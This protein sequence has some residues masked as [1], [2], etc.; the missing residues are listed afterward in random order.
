MS[1][2]VE[3]GIATVVLDRPEKLNACTLEEHDQIARIVADVDGRE[4]VAAVVITGAGRAFSVGGDLGLL[5]LINKHPEG[6]LEHLSQGARAVVYS[7]LETQ[8]PWVAAVNGPAMGVGTII[9]LLCDF[10]VMERSARIA[11]GHVRAAVSAGDGGTVIWPLT[12]GVMKAKQYLL[13]G[14]WISAVDAERFGLVSEVVD[15]GASVARATAI[16]NRLAAGPTE[17]IRHTKR[18][19]NAWLKVGMTQNFEAAL[20]HEG[21]TMMSSAAA[22]AIEGLQTSGQGAMPPDE[23]ADR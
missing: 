8:K 3:S 20:L 2:T 12:V 5:E 10:V 13:T 1:V 15:D 14:D 7:L 11:D 21:I 22:T 6:N 17:A 18:S 4:D 23:L 9:A 16:A 19:L